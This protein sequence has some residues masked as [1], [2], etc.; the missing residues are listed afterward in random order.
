MTKARQLADLGNAYDD[1]ALSN[2][3]LIINGAMKVAQRGTSSTGIGSGAGYF[4]CDRW[5]ITGTNSTGRLTM[6]Q[7]SDSPSGFANSMKLAC[8]TADTSIGA[9]EKLILRQILEGQ[10]LQQFAKGTSDAKEFTV[11]FY[12]KGNASATYVFELFDSDNTRQISKTFSV[13]TDWTRI[14]LTYPADIVGAFA[15]DNGISLYAQIWLHAGSDF[16]SGTLNSSAWASQTVANRASSSG[17]SFFDSTN[18]TF[19]ITGVQLEV[20]DTATPF[21]HRSYGDELAKCQRYYEKI[22]LHDTYRLNG[23][24]WSADS[25]NIS[26]P[27]TVT[28]RVSPSISVP[29][30]GEVFTG[31]WVTPTLAEITGATINGGT[32]NIKKTGSYTVKYGYFIRYQDI[33]IDA[34]L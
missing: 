2:R 29:S 5:S 24:A 1:G 33:R 27:F 30:I 23:V 17:T 21:E 28:K 3:N 7:E 22:Y 9:S 8:T 13:T 18:R 16:T 12:V 26:F 31:S 32:L 14:I 10:D 25:Q 11:S 20:G 19:Q 15:D 34:E 4:T 6:T